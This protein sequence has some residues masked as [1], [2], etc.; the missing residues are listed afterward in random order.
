MTIS[1]D[2]SLNN[3]TNLNH[4]I[5]IREFD[6]ELS[7]LFYNSTLSPKNDIRDDLNKLI[8]KKICTLK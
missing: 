3:Q 1:T 7:V 5:K 4:M 6:N 2:L 8:C